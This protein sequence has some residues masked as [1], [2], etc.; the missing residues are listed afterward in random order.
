MDTREPDNWRARLAAALHG[1]VALMCVG[2]RVRG[3]DGAGP[4]LADRLALDEP[5]KVFDCGVAPE[6]WIG[7][8]CRF[9]PDVVALVD[10]IDFAAAPGTIRC[11]DPEH[12]AD[13]GLSTHHASLSLTLGVICQDTG[14]AALV[15]GIQPQST[16]FGEGLSE[17]VEAAVG[18]LAREL[19]GGAQESGVK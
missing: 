1:R 16:G 2:N 19:R 12:L 11:W 6:N 3:D 7:P 8:V 5:W 4:A 18:A 17:A 9:G 10:A 14:A 13:V 15:V